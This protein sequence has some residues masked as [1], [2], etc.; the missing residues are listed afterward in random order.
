MC[1]GAISYR[2]LFLGSVV[3]NFLLDLANGRQLLK[4]KDPEE[5]GRSGWSSPTCS[6]VCACCA[7]ARVPR[8][9]K[10]S[11]RCSYRAL[12]THFH[13]PTIFFK[14][15]NF[16]FFFLFQVW[17]SRYSLLDTLTFST[18]LYKSLIKGLLFETSALDFF[19]FFT[20]SWIL[21]F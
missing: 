6:L 9:Q 13:F 17:V 3:G 2:L 8:W 5:R 7:P 12:S 21:L 4:I 11:S 1:K 20:L 19:L 16:F 18:T 15:L 10:L 14:H